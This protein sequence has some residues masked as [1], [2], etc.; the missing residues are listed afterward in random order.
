MAH[1]VF[2][3][4]FRI[5]WDERGDAAAGV[6]ISAFFFLPRHAR[7]FFLTDMKRLDYDDIDED[8]FITTRTTTTT[9]N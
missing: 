9:R 5:N 6:V 8:T 2:E 7:F 4:C 3:A 1:G